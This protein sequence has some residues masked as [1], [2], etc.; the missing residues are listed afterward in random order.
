MGGSDWLNA[1]GSLFNPPQQDFNGAHLG[2]FAGYQ[3]Q[4]SNNVVIGL[5]GDV[6]YDWN[7]KIFVSGGG[8]PADIG[9]DWG[10]SVRARVGYAFDHL[11]VYTTGGW[12]FARAFVRPDGFP[13]AEE[14]YNG[15]TVGAGIDYAFTDNIFARAEY[16]YADF[17]GKTLASGLDADL[18]QHL[19][20]VGIGVKY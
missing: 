11:L 16:R 13:S 10:G 19:F 3:Y 17:G 14:T 20:N 2:A 6:S 5:E 15:Y 9:T 4:F 18:K 12:A 8:T 1:N 7:K